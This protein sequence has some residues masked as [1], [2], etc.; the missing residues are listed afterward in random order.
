MATLRG[1]AISVPRLDG[2]ANIAAA[3]PRPSTR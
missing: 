3:T 1:F 2:Q